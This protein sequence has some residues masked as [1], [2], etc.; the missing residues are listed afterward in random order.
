MNKLQAIR[1]QEDTHASRELL[2][3]IREQDEQTALLSRLAERPKF[4]PWNGKWDHVTTFHTGAGVRFLTPD[5]VV[6]A[7]QGN[8]L[9]K[10][11]DWGETWTSVDGTSEMPNITQ[12]SKLHSGE[13]IVAT[14]G[15]F[16]YKSDPTEDNWQEVLAYGEGKGTTMQDFGFQVYGDLVLCASYGGEQLTNCVW[17]SRD[18]GET[19]DEILSLPGTAPGAD[20]D[21]ILHFH[22]VKFDPYES[23]IWAVTGDEYLEGYSQRNRILW[24]ADWGATWTEW[25]GYRATQ[26]VPLPGCVLFISDEQSRTSVARYDRPLAGTRAISEVTPPDHLGEWEDPKFGVRD[27][28]FT[29]KVQTIGTAAGWGSNA[30]VTYGPD[31]TAVFSWHQQAGREWAPVIYATHDGVTFVVVWSAPEAGGGV[32]GVFGP[33]ETG[34]YAASYRDTDGITYLVKVLLN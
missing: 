10:S 6:Y 9:R 2:T 19:F 29:Y 26:I 5:G 12:V 23:L 27:T 33:D 20:P 11:S 13:L 16:I 4:T 28:F 1:V 14:A 3:T 21:P 25:R 15:G 22:D 24:S 34:A 31:A 17:L 18:A 8:D 32:N 7:S 30:A